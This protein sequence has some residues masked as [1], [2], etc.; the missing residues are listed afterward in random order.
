MWVEVQGQSALPV[1]E[2]SDKLHSI[3]GMNN[4]RSD[5]VSGST[6]GLYTDLTHQGHISRSAISAISRQSDVE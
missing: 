1:H 6:V 4:W 5:H 3:A 2:L